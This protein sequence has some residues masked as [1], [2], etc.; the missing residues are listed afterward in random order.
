MSI[1]NCGNGAA[2]AEDRLDMTK[3]LKPFSS[4]WFAKACLREWMETFF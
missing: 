3:G 2:M 4:R 1:A